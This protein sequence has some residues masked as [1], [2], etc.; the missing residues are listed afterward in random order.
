MKIKIYFTIEF[1]L[2]I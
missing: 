1:N 2:K